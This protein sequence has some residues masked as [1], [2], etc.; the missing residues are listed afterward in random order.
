MG[1]MSGTLMALNK[2]GAQWERGGFG[3]GIMRF[4]KNGSAGG[5]RRWRPK[6]M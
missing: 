6:G 5:Q 4:S 2:R 3:G 1:D